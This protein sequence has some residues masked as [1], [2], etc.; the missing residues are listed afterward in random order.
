MA[1][2][3]HNFHPTQIVQL[4]RH[5]G[6]PHACVLDHKPH[7]RSFL[8]SML[9]EL[10]FATRDCGAPD[11]KKMLDEFGPDLIVLGPLNGPTEVGLLLQA[12]KFTGYHGRTMLF[13][14]RNSPVLMEMQELGERIG[15]PMLPPLGT[16]FRDGTLTD[17]IACFLP[18]ALPADLPIDADEALRNG[19]LEIWYQAKIDPRSLTPAGAEAI[20]RVRHPNWGLISPPTF[21][22]G[23]GDPYLRTFSQYVI[24]RAMADSVAFAA[25]SR[26]IDISVDLPVPALNDIEFVD[27]VLHA[28]PEHVSKRGLQVEVRCAEVARDLPRLSQIASRLAFRNIGISIDDVGAEGAALAGRHDLPVVELKVRRKYVRGC[29][30]DRVKQAVCS[31]I[32]A[33]AR[34][35]GARSVAVGVDTQADYLMTRELGI[36]L[37]QGALFSKPMEL[38]KFER[39]LARHEPA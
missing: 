4:G 13:G 12:L 17:N 3:Q 20:V 28:I 11:L 8:A 10:G 26:P 39:T 38:K 33:T 6:P 37:L 23:A 19:W 14:G 30:T 24:M 25:A 22:P 16:P 31:A 34:D 1:S 21:V 15:L 27:K 35:S 9:E 7:V 32:I 29:A 5:R 18:I 36:D 2:D